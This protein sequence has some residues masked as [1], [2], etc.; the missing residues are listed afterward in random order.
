VS[1]AT[2]EAG[3]PDS[4]VSRSTLGFFAREKSRQLSGAKREELIRALRR[5]LTQ[6][7]E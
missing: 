5:M 1:Q 7:R 2:K 4:E 3:V 6:A